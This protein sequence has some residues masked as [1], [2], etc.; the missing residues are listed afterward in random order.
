MA[1]NCTD[2]NK[3]FRILVDVD[4]PFVPTDEMDMEITFCPF[5][6]MNLEWNEEEDV[7]L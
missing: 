6:G 1:S 5:C 3:Q 7:D 4:G 2:C